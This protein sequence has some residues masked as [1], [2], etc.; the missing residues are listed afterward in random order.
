GVLAATGV[1]TTANAVTNPAQPLLFGAT[2]EVSSFYTPFKGKIDE[3]RLWNV[4]RSSTDVQH[5]Y[6]RPVDANTAGLV[7]YWKFDET[8]DVTYSD[9]SANGNTATLN[10]GVSGN[11]SSANAHQTG[12]SLITPAGTALYRIVFK[13][14]L[15]ESVHV[16]GDEA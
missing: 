14:S 2:N 1:V 6:R 5:D 16:P 4:A 3:V 10:V 13:D 12:Q 7:G 15:G 9:S 11:V 8:E